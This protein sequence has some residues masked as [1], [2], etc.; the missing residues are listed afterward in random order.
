MSWTPPKL[1][2]DDLNQYFPDNIPLPEGDQIFE[3]AL[4][5]GGTVSV[6]AYS[7]GVLDMLFL[8]LDAW[9]EAL[10]KKNPDAPDHKTI[11]KVMSGASGGAVCAAIASIAAP[12]EFP[13]AL[14][15]EPST[16][17]NPFFDLWVDTLDVAGMLV[18]DDIVKNQP[19]QSLLNVKPLNEGIKHLESFT[20]QKPIQRKWLDGT[21]AT[22]ITVTNLRG[23]PYALSLGDDKEYFVNHGDFARFQVATTPKG[24]DPR[25]DSFL[26][27]EIADRGKLADFAVASGAFPVGFCARQVSQP[28]G[29]YAY[30]VINLPSANPTSPATPQWHEPDWDSMRDSHGNLPEDWDFPCYDGGIIDNEPIELARK[31]LTGQIG[32]TP[33]NGADDT[34]RALIL[35]DPFADPV[36][37]GPKQKGGIM[38]MIGPF[39]G[40]MIAQGRYDTSDLQ[41]ALDPDVYSRFMIH[42]RR[43]VT[44]GGKAIAGAGLNAFQG[45]LSRDFRAH[46]YMLG[47]L[48]AYDY[49]KSQ[50]TLPEGHILFKNWTA[51]QKKKYAVA[52]KDGSIQLPIIP[53]MPSIAQPAM[54]DWPKGKFDPQSLKKPIA[55]RVSAVLDALENEEIPGTTLMNDGI[56]AVL[57]VAKEL[58]EPKLTEAILKTIT[59]NL[60]EWK[61]L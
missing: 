22:L 54:P 3:L 31:A 1:T 41:L 59:A 30:R 9:S 44:S 35:I 51:D 42:A 5:L 6:G 2:D 40:S 29:H 32:R 34:K 47:R 52:Q 36:S 27:N 24:A 33:R 11:L 58:G 19:L 61:L 37:L 53:V 23:V 15:I 7:A 17:G 46:D 12:L 49:L 28:C 43:G 57:W 25:P 10:D 55:K 21:L 8:A 26:V 45:F 48:N 16:T 60:Q 18:N 14:G 20:G 4:T 13:H 38:D 50:L 56:R 39:F